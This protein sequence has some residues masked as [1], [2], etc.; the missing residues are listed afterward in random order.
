M[1]MNLHQLY[2][3]I[4]S[5]WHYR[6]EFPLL[7]KN[8]AI[9]DAEKIRTHH[10]RIVN[11]MSFAPVTTIKNNKRMIDRDKSVIDSL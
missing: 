3:K 8:S 1:G 2:K 6:F 4:S 7:R 10:P 9:E 11:T 5:L